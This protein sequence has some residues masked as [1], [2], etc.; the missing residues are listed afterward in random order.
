MI[1]YIH[2]SNS[3]FNECP[4]SENKKAIRGEIAYRLLYVVLIYFWVGF[5]L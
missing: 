2:T 5:L 4:H 1:L 3:F